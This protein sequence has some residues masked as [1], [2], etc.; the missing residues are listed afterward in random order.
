MKKKIFFGLL[1]V[2]LANALGILR[3]ASDAASKL[4][5]E[6]QHLLSELNEVIDSNWVGD[7]LPDANTP[8]VIPFKVYILLLLLT[9]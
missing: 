1:V 7:S 3:Q 9:K 8:V 4:I 2:P 6:E 5:A